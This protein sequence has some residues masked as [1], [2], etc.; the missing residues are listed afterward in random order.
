MSP[1]P[2]QETKQYI[3][4]PTSPKPKTNQPNPNGISNGCLI[5]L[6]LLPIASVEG[7]AGIRAAV[8]AECVQGG[9]GMRLKAE[10]WSGDSGDCSL[11]PWWWRSMPEY[12]HPLQRALLG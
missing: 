3:I 4:F 6:S 1:C 8:S 7:M 5:Q 10:P 12:G 9:G 11:W 2:L